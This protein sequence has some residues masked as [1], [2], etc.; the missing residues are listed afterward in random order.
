MRVPDWLKTSGDADFT[1]LIPGACTAGTV[2]V[3]G[4]DTTGVVDPGGAAC[5]GAVLATG[6]AS[7]SAAVV[8]YVAV[9]VSDPPAASEESG[10]KIADSPGR[11]VSLTATEV[12]VTF[13]VLV[14]RKL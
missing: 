11:P 7:P 6:P 14:T 2:A 13:P 10:Q 1:T 4:A 9:H 5:A 3:D 8:V 12:S